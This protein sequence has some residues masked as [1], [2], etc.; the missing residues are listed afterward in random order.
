MNNRND[1]VINRDVV[2]YNTSLTEMH[3]GTGVKHLG[4]NIGTVGRAVGLVW[5]GMVW[6]V[7]AGMVGQDRHIFSTLIALITRQH[8]FDIKDWNIPSYLFVFATN[9]SKETPVEFLITMFCWRLQ[10][11]LG[12]RVLWLV[13]SANTQLTPHKFGFVCQSVFGMNELPKSISK[14]IWMR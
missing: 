1:F 3:S 10:K 12:L 13:E 4:R 9:N 2:L 14:S 11:A 7:W 5:M 6:M 8:I